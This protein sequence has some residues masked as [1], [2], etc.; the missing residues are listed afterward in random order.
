MKSVIEIVRFKLLE[1]ATS[2][3]LVSASEQ[4]QKF[5]SSLNGFEYRSLS[6]DQ[7]SGTWTDVVYWDSMDNAKAAGEQFMASEDCKP[8]MAL[9]DPESVIMQ[10]QA[11]MMSDLAAKYQ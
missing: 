4:S 6:F 11:I 1:N 9:I 5:V 2:E 7:D 8:L 10:H 3:Q